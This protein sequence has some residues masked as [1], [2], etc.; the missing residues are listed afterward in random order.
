MTLTVL[1]ML[2]YLKQMQINSVSA[3]V[4]FKNMNSIKLLE[5]IGFGIVGEKDINGQ[6][7][8]DVSIK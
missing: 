4:D 6:I 3:I 7:H 2:K 8:Y 1:R 5:K